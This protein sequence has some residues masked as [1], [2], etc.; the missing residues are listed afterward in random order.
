MVV[1]RNIWLYLVR[2]NIDYSDLYAQLS[3]EI[4]KATQTYCPKTSAL[5][6]GNRML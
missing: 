4:V 5:N 6:L 3:C 1:N 2:K